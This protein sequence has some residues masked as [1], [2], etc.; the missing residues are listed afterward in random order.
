MTW[1]EEMNGRLDVIK[2]RL[3]YLETL[4]TRPYERD[5]RGP[6]EGSLAA[7]PTP[8][9]LCFNTTVPANN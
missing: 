6:T 5:Y 3:T 7:V 9:S 1:N 4:P 8:S 2:A